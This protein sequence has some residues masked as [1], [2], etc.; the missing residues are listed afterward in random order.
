MKTAGKDKKVNMGFTLIEL[1]VAL[2]IAAILVGVAAPNMSA[3]WQESRLVSASETVYSH[4]QL[5]RSVALARNTEITVDFGNTGG[6]NW[7][8]AISENNACDCAAGTNCTLTNM[9]EINITGSEYG[10]ITLTTTFTGHDTSITIPRGMASDTGTVVLQ[11][12]S[13]NDAVSVAL[14]AIGRVQLCS[15]ELN[16]YEC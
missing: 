16:Q 5:A 9:P 13:S 3:F 7:C 1:L 2:A 14:S 11:S 4:M 8:M 15:N 10:N 6:T 12:Q